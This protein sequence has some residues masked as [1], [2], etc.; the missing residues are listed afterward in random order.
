MERALA[1]SC[2]A[3]TRAVL[4]THFED[5]SR[6]I[7]TLHKAIRRTV[8]S[9]L[10][11]PLQKTERDFRTACLRASTAELRTPQRTTAHRIWN[12][13]LVRY[14]TFLKKSDSTAAGGPPKVSAI[15]IVSNLVSFL[16]MLRHRT[17]KSSF[18][19][20]GTCYALTNAFILI[21]F[22]VWAAP[23]TIW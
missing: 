18:G 16:V 12:F 7:Q 19:L 6:R 2:E 15:G 22:A 8:S 14:K 5:R 9:S 17:F 23:W 1:P 21:I 11:H 13:P 3:C 4:S 10:G 20:L